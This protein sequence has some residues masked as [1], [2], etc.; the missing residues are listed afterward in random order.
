MAFSLLRR[1][2]AS[3]FTSKS[4]LKLSIPVL[5]GATLLATG[6]HPRVKDPNDPKFIVAEK[7]NWTITR[8][9]LDKEISAY[10]QQHQMTIDQVG[11]AN[12]PKLETFML[13]NM[14]LKKLILDRAAALQLKDV[15]K[16]EA[17]ELDAIKGRVPPGQDLDTELKTVGLTMDDLKQRI[18]D[19]VIVGKVME[20]EAF[21]DT[22]PTEAE[23]SD[24]YTKNQDKF[25]LAPQVR[26]SRVLVLV[27]E[28]ASPADKAAK[29][30]KIDDAHA[31][32]AKGEDFGKVATAV[33]EDK[34]SAP[35]N[36]DLGWFKKGETGE[37]ELEELAFNS[38][39]GVVSAVFES[40]MGYEFIKVTDTKAGGTASLADAS[41][42]ISDYLA[43]QKKRD[44]ED[45]YTTKLLNDGGVTFYLKRVDLHAPDA[46]AAP[47]GAPG[48][49][50][51][52][53]QAPAPAD[54]AAPAPASADQAAPAPATPP[55]AAPPAK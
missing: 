53:A 7:G 55:P 9:E 26:A 11:Q 42:K 5:L 36:G 29:K 19:Q 35:R 16:D 17:A 34:Y 43:S 54:Q 18:H 1:L 39:T 45:A 50:S 22:T 33:S 4:L 44:Q 31:R 49:P 27:D 32:V 51:A 41:P 37:P 15:D 6:C 48:A 14:V 28:K 38:K 2:R 20:A 21:K 8:G 12:I 40:P 23:I 3:S 25:V 30:Q 46:P 10:L 13:D 52:E 24:F 47:T